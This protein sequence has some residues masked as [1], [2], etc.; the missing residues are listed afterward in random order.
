[1][2]FHK[3]EEEIELI[4]HGAL[5]LSKVHGEIASL[6]KEGVATSVLDKRAEEFIK[7]H[8]AQ[9]SF[10]NYN[11]FPYSLCISPNAVVVHGFPGKYTL[12]QGDVISVDCGVFFKGFHSDCAYTHAV[13]E[14]SE[15][16]NKLLHVTKES[17]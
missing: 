16:V 15:E 14:V 9:P 7:D 2:I 12:K 11:G 6:I 3:T 13:G 17:L 1:M 4:R 5:I 8:G 10:L